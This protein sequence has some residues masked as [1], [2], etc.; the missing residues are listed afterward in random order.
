MVDGIGGGGGG[1][2]ELDDAIAGD[3]DAAVL[4]K[5]AAMASSFVLPC[6]TAYEKSRAAGLLLRVGD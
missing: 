5:A 4:R 1:G 2:S 6:F 3:G